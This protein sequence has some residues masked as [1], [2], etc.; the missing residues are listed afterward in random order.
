MEGQAMHAARAL[1]ESTRLICQAF[2][3][4]RGTRG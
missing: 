4:F 3:F 2:D 1:Q